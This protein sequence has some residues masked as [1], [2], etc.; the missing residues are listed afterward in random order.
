MHVM[1]PIAVRRIGRSAEH[2]IHGG[3][4]IEIWLKDEGEIEA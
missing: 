4:E 3:L 2:R 1:W